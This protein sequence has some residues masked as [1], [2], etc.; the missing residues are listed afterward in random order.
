[1][2]N[3]TKSNLFNRIE[4]FHGNLPIMLWSW[5]IPRNWNFRCGNFTLIWTEGTCEWNWT[6]FSFDD[7][8][9]GYEEPGFW[10]V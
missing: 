6:G 7:D 5:C 8:W 4:G 9:P 1:M 10:N 2:V 3:I